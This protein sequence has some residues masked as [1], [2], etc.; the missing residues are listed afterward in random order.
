MARPLVEVEIN[1]NKVHALLDTGSRRAYIRSELAKECPVVPVQP[2]QVRLGGNTFHLEE[3]HVVQGIV[4]DSQKTG[5]RFSAILFPVEDLGEEAGK[6]I[7]LLFG[8]LL[9]EDWGAVIDES[10]TPPKVDYSL[11]KKGGLVEL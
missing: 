2:F 6:Q 10:T 1:G 8:A 3:G 4:K 7:D 9:L 5:Y 11:L